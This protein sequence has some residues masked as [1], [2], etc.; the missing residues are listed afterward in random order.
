MG[1]V[2]GLHRF[3]GVVISA[4]LLGEEHQVTVAFRN[5]LRAERKGRK[6]EF[7]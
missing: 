6:G 7:G 3:F 4:L 1:G 5:G 2:A